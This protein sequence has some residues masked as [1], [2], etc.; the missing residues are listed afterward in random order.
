MSNSKFRANCCPRH[1][2]LTEAEQ[3]ISRRSFLAAGGVLMGG[4][5]FAAMQGALLASDGTRPV[6]MPAP[7]KPLIVKPILTRDLPVP[8]APELPPTS[9]RSWGEV[10]TV[11]ATNAEAARIR[12]E[13][14]GMKQRADYPVDFRELAVI[15]HVGEVINHPDVVECDVILL[16]AA[17]GGALGVENLGKDVIIFTRRDDGPFYLINQ[18]GSPIL[19]RQYSDGPVLQNITYNDLVADNVEDVEWRLRSLCGLKNTRGQKIVTIGGTLA[20]G[21]WAKGGEQGEFVRETAER[22]MKTWGFEYHDVSYPELSELIRG[23]MADRAVM[24]RAERRTAEHLRIPNTRL[25][26]K[27][28]YLVKCFMLD[29]LFRAIMQKAGTNIITVGSCM[30]T[31]LPVSQTAACYTLTTL[32]DDGYLAFCESDMV[33]IPSGILL[34]NI[35]GKPVFFCNPTFPNNGIFTVAHCSAPRKMDG[36]NYDPVRILTHMESDV[37]AAPWVQAPVGTE[38]TLLGPSFSGTRW[39]G[40]KGTV[41][42]VPFHQICRTQFDISY[43]FPDDLLRENLV[44]FHWMTCYGDYRKEVA[45]ALRRVG[46]EWNNLN[47]VPVTR[48]E[49]AQTPAPTTPARAPGLFPN[50]PGPLR[51]Q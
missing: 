2:E 38:I 6:A 24:E 51:R 15:G 31:I 12:G 27:R 3:E 9:W 13:I 10:Q 4:L 8:P 44:G 7:R 50:R 14:E 30:T 28:E 35:V 46:I 42:N 23:A 1:V 32:N 22:A 43:N 18:I 25:E 47:T 20:W 26:T 19:L 17:G 5:S 49:L 48:E 40:F 41:A 29:D 11:E 39:T 16:Y 36:K 45:Y 34:G 37:G 33:V 21:F